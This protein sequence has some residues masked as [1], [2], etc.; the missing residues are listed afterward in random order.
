MPQPDQFELNLEAKIVNSGEN[1]SQP[2]NVAEQTSRLLQQEHRE[3]N[4]SE[5][6]EKSESNLISNFRG[7]G[8]TRDSYPGRKLREPQ[9][10]DLKRIQ[11]DRSPFRQCRVTLQI[12]RLSSSGS[13][14]SISKMNGSEQ[15][16]KHHH[17]ESN[18]R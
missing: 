2:R 9:K 4:P 16:S 17:L 18:L 13:I 14:E 10:D 3:K 6:Q 12:E 11:R 15:L 8:M 5:G 1:E 7:I